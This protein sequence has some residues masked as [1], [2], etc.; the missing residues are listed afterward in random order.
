ELIY[1]G[2]LEERY[3]ELA[4]HYS[5]SRN[6]RKAV[7][8]LQLAGQQALQRSSYEEAI[9]HLA[10]ALKMLKAAPDTPKRTHQELTLQ[11]ALRD[12][13]VVINGYTASEVEKTVLRARELCQQIGETPQ[14]SP[15]L[16]RLWTFYINRGEL[17]TTRELA[18]QLMR[19]AQNVQDPY[20]L[21]MAH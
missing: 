16:F 4:H 8:Y 2:N 20:L 1:K 7:E 6:T 15:V 19:L 10:K 17:E 13:L 3:R 11:L 5:H 12:A 21:S 9:A 14:L 18:E